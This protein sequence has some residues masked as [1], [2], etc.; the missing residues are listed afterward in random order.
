MW[1]HS[2]PVSDQ[3]LRGIQSYQILDLACS[4]RWTRAWKCAESEMKSNTKLGCIDIS[5]SCW[6][7]FCVQICMLENKKEVLFGELCHPEPQHTTPVRPLAAVAGDSKPRNWRSF[8][9]WLSKIGYEANCSC[10]SHLYRILFF[11]SLSRRFSRSICHHLFNALAWCL[12]ARMDMSF[13]SPALHDSKVF[14]K[15]AVLIRYS[16]L[17]LIFRWLTLTGII[18]IDQSECAR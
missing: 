12:T 10:C 6:L 8:I 3:Q 7:D 2:F 4:P 14:A 5:Q 16:D 1:Y 18:Q 11:L 9:F 17:I 15:I 13:S